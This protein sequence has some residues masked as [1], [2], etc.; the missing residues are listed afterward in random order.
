[1]SELWYVFS[2]DLRFMFILVFTGICFQIVFKII[3]TTIFVIKIRRVK[4]MAK[5]SLIFNDEL[6]QN[7]NEKQQE[8][9]CQN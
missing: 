3:M 6:E 5:N 9:V 7:K 1:M 4:E 2:E 8:E